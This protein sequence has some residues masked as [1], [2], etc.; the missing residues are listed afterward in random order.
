MPL[1]NNAIKQLYYHES[2]ESEYISQASG[3][4]AADYG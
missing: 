4:Q 3:F 1:V 2:D